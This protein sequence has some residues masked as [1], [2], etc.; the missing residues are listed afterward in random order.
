MIIE[1]DQRDPSAKISVLFFFIHKTLPF[2]TSF[3]STILILFD[4]P[5]NPS[6]DFKLF[7]SSLFNFLSIFFPEHLSV[8]LF[9][10][11]HSSFRIRINL[12]FILFKINHSRTPKR[13]FRKKNPPQHLSSFYITF[14][15]SLYSKTT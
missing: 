14:C 3:F 8:L 9:L 6:L 5:S 4:Y 10:Q 12:S 2:F 13:L 15:L 7:L 1:N 11:V